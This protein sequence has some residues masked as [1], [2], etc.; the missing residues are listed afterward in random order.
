MNALSHYGEV[1]VP[2]MSVEVSS[3]PVKNVE[4]LRSKDNQESKPKRSRYR[5]RKHKARQND[6][7]SLPEASKQTEDQL[8]L[9]KIR[10]QMAKAKVMEMEKQRQEYSTHMELKYSRNIFGYLQLSFQ[11]TLHTKFGKPT[12]RVD[13][14]DQ[15]P[16]GPLNFSAP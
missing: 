2:P 1:Q 12:Y 6:F 7:P 15:A 3:V 8:R 16:A 14:F 10:I 5:K 11:E 4:L 9:E 13:T